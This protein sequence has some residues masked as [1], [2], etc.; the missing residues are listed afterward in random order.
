VQVLIEQG[1]AVDITDAA[2]D[3]PLHYAVK[4][5]NV[6]V[7]AFLLHSKAS[8]ALANKQGQTPLHYAVRHG[9]VECVVRLVEA[10]ADIRAADRDKVTPYV[11]AKR[12]G[13]PQMRLMFK[14]LKKNNHQTGLGKH[15]FHDFRRLRAPARP[16]NNVVSAD[17]GMASTSTT[18]VEKSISTST[19]ATLTAK[20][21]ATY[22][23][24]TMA[25][26]ALL[27]PKR[28]LTDV[29]FSDL[30]EVVEVVQSEAS[31]QN[32]RT[33]Y[34]SVLR[35]LL[36]VPDDLAMGT[37]VLQVLEQAMGLVLMA[38]PRKAVRLDT[39]PFLDALRKKGT[40][41]EVQRA[42]ALM[43]I[44][45]ALP[46]LF[47][48][49][50]SGLK[51]PRSSGKSPRGIQAISPRGPAAKPPPPPPPPPMLKRLAL[52]KLSTSESATSSAATLPSVT[53]TVASDA[54]Q[55][56]EGLV[57]EPVAVNAPPLPP[58]V[59]AGPP[60]PPML[61]GV[62][63]SAQQQRV[64]LRKLNW[65]KVPIGLIPKTVWSN[66]RPAEFDTVALTEDF[67][68]RDPKK[69]TKLPTHAFA[70]TAGCLPRY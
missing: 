50:R 58:P 6:H 9:A 66:A 54:K 41:D 40:I 32:L 12:E 56:G 69:V 42:E 64:K 65:E 68:E 5:N 1:V 7:A 67:Q 60:P 18:G 35:L 30:A 27:S 45:R 59:N 34:A 52:N 29:N 4:R 26:P 17:S 37:K 20:Q 24:V 51:T 31:K 62:A 15:V 33:A 25:P 14:F 23:A 11:L 49:R 36:L 53:I 8:V 19:S 2:G 63:R 47:D 46:Q 55:A 10:G 44:E 48:E 22:A 38:D 57:M 28:V 21:R 39:E 16:D 3:T 43:M 70:V 61:K 13:D